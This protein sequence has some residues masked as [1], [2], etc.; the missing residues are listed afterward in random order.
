MNPRNLRQRLTRRSPHSNTSQEPTKENRIDAV[1]VAVL[2][3]E[4]RQILDAMLIANEDVYA[5]LK[6]RRKGLSAS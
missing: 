4:G 6:E 5:V 3:V 2:I 1:L